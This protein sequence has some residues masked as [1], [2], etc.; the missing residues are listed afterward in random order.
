MYVCVC[1]RVVAHETLIA[2]I[3]LVNPPPLQ[4]YSATTFCDLMSSLISQR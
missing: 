2:V 3:P 1:V 4:A